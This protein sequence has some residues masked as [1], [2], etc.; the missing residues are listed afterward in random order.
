MNELNGEH[1]SGNTETNGELSHTDKMVGVF[2][3]PDR[4]FSTM[5]KFAVK[6]SDWLIP[7][8]VLIIVS[9]VANLAMMN[10]P[11][12]KATIMEKSITQIEK[13]LNEAVEAGKLSQEKAD[14][15]LEKIRDNMEKSM[16]S[17]ILSFV[18]PFLYTFIMFFIVSGI[19]F[20]FAKFALGGEGTYS[21]SMVSYGLPH[22][23]LAVQSIIIVILAL[24]T[25]QP[26]RDLS[27][28]TFLDYDRT[29][30]AGFL[31]GK[32]DVFAIWFYSVVSIAYARMFKSESTGKYFAMIFGLWI[33]FGL[34]MFAGAKFLPFLRGF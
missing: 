16:G 10:N 33:G 12:I 20:L 13:N 6:N 11:I 30:I 15:Q 31:L 1:F 23:I 29:T 25:D 3:E 4:I 17:P 7:I 19:F 8:F 32:L 22:Y 14:E 9:V 21:T 18:G 26:Y 28:A 34:L 27:L 5:S 2:T 24:A